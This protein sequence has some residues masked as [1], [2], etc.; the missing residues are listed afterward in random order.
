MSLFKYYRP[1]N[2]MLALSP[3]AAYLPN[4]GQ[5]VSGG[6]LTEWQDQSGNGYHATQGD[7][8]KQPAF[9]ASE[10][11]FRNN[12]GLSFDGVDDFLTAAIGSVAVPWT[13]VTVGTWD[14]NNATGPFVAA[15]AA[16]PHGLRHIS[17]RPT[18]VSSGSNMMAVD[19]PS[20]GTPFIFIGTGGDG[21][22][23]RG[24]FRTSGVTSTETLAGAGAGGLSGINIGSY[25][26]GLAPWG[27]ELTA[28]LVF[29]RALTTDEINEISDYAAANWV[30][31]APALLFDLDVD[32]AT[33][34]GSDATL[35]PD[36][37]ANS[38]DFG[39]GVAIPTVAS[40]SDFNSHRS[41]NPGA[42]SQ[43]LDNDV[44][45]IPQQ[46]TLFFVATYVN[47]SGGLIKLNTFD[48]S[49]GYGISR[50]TSSGT[51]SLSD[52]SGG[53]VDASPTPPAGPLVGMAIF[54]G[55][56]NSELH[57]H[58]DGQTPTI[59]TGTLSHSDNELGAHIMTNRVFTAKW[60][61][62]AARFIMYKGVLDSDTY[63]TIISDLKTTYGITTT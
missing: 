57:I 16:A 55:G 1:T 62:K 63:D 49:N 20:T 52:E 35:V 5:I 39:L 37:S 30:D 54:T 34:S 48:D 27:G 60:D 32:D 40:D 7:T 9:T 3:I 2:P 61:G 6:K 13:F 38:Y 21:S 25:G 51:I 14:H 10:A 26:G 47:T 59:D 31:V 8:G 28:V 36:S 42:N 43:R 44:V 12:P 11:N 15:S 58:A 50:L 4:R 24:H 46:W 53:S 45:P 17:D 56:A 18:I 29:D 22:N 23:D 41:L 19:A 33:L